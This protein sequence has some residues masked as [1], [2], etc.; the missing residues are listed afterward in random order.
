MPTYLRLGRLIMAIKLLLKIGGIWKPHGNGI[1]SHLY[2]VYSWWFIFTFS[3]MFTA[4]MCANLYFLRDI[5][6]LTDMLSMSMTELALVLK[7]IN[8][9]VNNARMQLML[10]RM[11]QFRM[12][13]RNDEAIMHTRLVFLQRTT[14][15]FYIFM[16]ISM[17]SS[18]MNAAVSGNEKLIYSAYYPGIDWKH[19]NVSYWFLFGYQYIGML[20]TAQINLAIDTYFCIMMYLVSGQIVILGNHLSNMG[21]GNKWTG[22][23][24]FEQRSMLI[25]NV[26]IHNR[27]MEFIEN[28]Q[29]CLWWSFSGQLC[30]S[31]VA[32]GSVATEMLRVSVFL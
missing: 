30:L 13:T 27:I 25:K 29:Y 10:K 16:Y 15:I 17:H 21:T 31:A 11:Q 4:F 24:T 2:K 12:E 1:F 19:N 9:Y 14:M 23:S 32:V 3:I 5:S 6:Q 18:T 7:I 20:L 26:K 22:K 28:L 8:F